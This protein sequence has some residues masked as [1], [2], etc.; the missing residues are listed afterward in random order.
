MLKPKA[1]SK[2]DEI[3]IISPS[4]SLA[5]MFPHRLENA[6]KFLDN[7]SIASYFKLSRIPSIIFSIH[8]LLSLFGMYVITG[9]SYGVIKN[10]D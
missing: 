7:I 5:G 10:Q 8:A 1:L 3:A 6:K 2:G 4:A 9:G